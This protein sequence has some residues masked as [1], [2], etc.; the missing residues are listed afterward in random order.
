MTR[1]HLI[2]TMSG[3]VVGQYRAKPRLYRSDRLKRSVRAS[4][5]RNDVILVLT[6]VIVVGALYVGSL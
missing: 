2:D 4:D 5:P 1:Y 3:E 6:A